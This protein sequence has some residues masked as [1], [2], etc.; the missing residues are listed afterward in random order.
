MDMKKTGTFKKEYN[1]LKRTVKDIDESKID[2]LDG[3]METAAFNYA[4]MEKCM[5]QI[6]KE[7]SVVLFQNGKQTFHKK[8]PAMDV[9]N[10]LLSKYQNT[11]GK[12]ISALKPS[13]SSGASTTPSTSIADLNNLRN[14]KLKAVK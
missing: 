4:E 1:R 2:L 13:A 11:M 14:K 6:E 3:L 7:G 12:I 9:Y 10:T 8:H 5:I